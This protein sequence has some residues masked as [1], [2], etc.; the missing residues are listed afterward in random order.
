MKDHVAK[1]L[2]PNNVEGVSRYRSHSTQ[3]ADDRSSS[4]SSD[5]DISSDESSI[6]SSD[7]CSSSVETCS[8]GQSSSLALTV[9]KIDSSTCLQSQMDL[10]SCV[11]SQTRLEKSS[12]ECTES[13]SEMW[14]DGTDSSS[15]ITSERSHSDDTKTMDNSQKSMLHC[16]SR[17]TFGLSKTSLDCPSSARFGTKSL[18][19]MGI[20]SRDSYRFSEYLQAGKLRNVDYVS[21][22]DVATTCR[23][24]SIIEPI[25]STAA[26]SAFAREV[27]R[28]V[29]ACACRDDVSSIGGLSHMPRT[30]NSLSPEQRSSVNQSYE[31]QELERKKHELRKLE[32]QAQRLKKM[33]MQALKERAALDIEGSVER[34]G[35]G[36]DRCISM[37]ELECFFIGLISVS[38]IILIILMALMLSTGEK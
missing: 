19:V 38:L 2:N 6:H 32:A 4:N 33:R 35:K 8:I 29:D 10:S 36:T 12:V 30:G 27:P 31:I 22:V 7:Y 1:F 16:Q 5:Y 24:L 3:D 23:G 34:E 21:G 37:Q 14:E 13:S 28:T 17:D 26:S 15:G 20:S 9:S 11:Q 25:S 18:T